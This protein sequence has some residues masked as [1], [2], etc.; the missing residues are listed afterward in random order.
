MQIL[1][2]KYDIDLDQVL[3][4]FFYLIGPVLGGGDWQIKMSLGLRKHVG[5]CIVAVSCRWNDAHKLSNKFVGV[6]GPYERQLMWE[7]VY[8]RHALERSRSCAV[9][10]LSA[11]S[12]VSP[13]NDGNPYGIDTIGEMGR[14]Q[15][16]LEHDR[17]LRV[18][19]GV[20]TGFPRLSVIV[21]NWDDAYGKSF[22]FHTSIEDTAR[23]AA[24]L[25]NLA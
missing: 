21:P 19:A 18:V 14:F 20:E 23:A 8:I 15:G 24:T 10:W 7:Q 13:R 2:P 22:P 25:V 4:P 1:R 3:L 5:N 11:E 6:Q 9:C 16:R 12:K 17:G